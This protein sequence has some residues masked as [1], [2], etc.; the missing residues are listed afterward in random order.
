MAHLRNLQKR[1][2]GIYYVRAV[3]NGRQL[4]QS[5]ATSDKQVAAAR[6]KGILESARG[7]RWDA[8]MGVRQ[9]TAY[10]TL[11]AIVE[12]YRAVAGERFKGH[13]RPRPAT[14]EGYIAQL[15][16][17]VRVVHENVDVKSLSSAVLQADL[18]RKYASIAL[19]PYVRVNDEQ[20]AER[21]RRTVAGTLRNARAVFSSWACEGMS[22]LRLP[23]L[24]GFLKTRVV[25]P[26]RQKYRLP[27]RS[28]IEKTSIEAA[29]L[30]QNR[31]ALYAVYL[32][33]Y[34]MGLRAGEAAAARWEW[35]VLDESQR[36]ID[37]RPREHFRTK[38]NRS[39]RIPVGA[40][41]MVHLQIL[42]RPADPFILDGGSPS[43]RED[44]I[45]REFA[46]WMRGIGWDARTYP[47]AAHELRKL[48][49]SEWYTRHGAECAANWLGD[50]LQVACEYYCD[51]KRHPEPVD[52]EA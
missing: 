40:T 31:P 7:A 13:G 15:F 27:P 32:L 39:R 36:Y 34:Y 14:I 29:K 3:V 22:D 37:V 33:C 1:A 11:G 51:L 26:E 28:L 10:A 2:N 38:N 35:F 6:A 17:L 16:N 4:Y 49:G 9:K 18:V 19:E 48:V 20:Y 50:T 41:V 8:V 42:R 45:K 47:K 21:G 25:H 52:V 12:R 43:A 44:L 24:D 30:R 46:L 23:V 5:L